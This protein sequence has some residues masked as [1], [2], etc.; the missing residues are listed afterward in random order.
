MLGPLL[1]KQRDRAGVSLREVQRATGVSYARLCEIENGSRSN[2]TIDT[3]DRLRRYYGIEPGVIFLA[4]ARTARANS[5]KAPHPA[6]KEGE[7]E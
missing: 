1:R 5:R 3:L 6:A 4:A 7:H 2:P